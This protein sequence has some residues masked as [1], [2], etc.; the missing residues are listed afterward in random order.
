MPIGFLLVLKDTEMRL[1]RTSLSVEIS[2]RRL[3]DCRLA[4]DARW[5]SLTTIIII[6]DQITAF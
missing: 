1:S 4:I 6:N 5:P 3:A 2:M